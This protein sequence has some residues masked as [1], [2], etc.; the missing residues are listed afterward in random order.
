VAGDIPLHNWDEQQKNRKEENL[1]K[2][3][4]TTNRQ[5][6]RAIGLDR[7]ALFLNQIR[8]WREAESLPEIAAMNSVKCAGN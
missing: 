1:K 4:E 6:N 8:K 3:A 7:Y 5:T 2:Q